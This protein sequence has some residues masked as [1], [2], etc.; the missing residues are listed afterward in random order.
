MIPLLLIA[1]MASAIPTYNVEKS[2]QAASKA[3]QD[4]SGYKG[5]VDDENAAKEKV[6][7]EW[8]NYPA[9][10]RQ[11]CASN[12]GGDQSNSYVELMTCFEM[13]DWK[14]DLNDVGGTHVPGAHGPQIR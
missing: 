9:A 12:Q 1:V 6:A 13:Q 8:A 10:A 4:D 2:C 14:K 5:C 3:T 11:E 7:K